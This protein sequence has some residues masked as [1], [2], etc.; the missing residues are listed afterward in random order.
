M[1]PFRVTV[2]G[3][4]RQRPVWAHQKP[5]T[6]S[7]EWFSRYRTTTCCMGVELFEVV[8][9]DVDV[10]EVVLVVDDVDVDDVVEEVVEED[11]VDE[12][13]V[14]VVVTTS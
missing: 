10:D 14:V 2:A 1:P 4:P 5:R 9:D 12:V 11:V 6:L 3:I 13:V 7:N 8:V